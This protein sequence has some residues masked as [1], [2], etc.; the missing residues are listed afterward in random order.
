[1]TAHITIDQS[2][3]TDFCR[4]WDIV[5]FSLFGSVLRDDFRLDSDVDVLVSF[6]QNA[7]HGLFDLVRM[8]DE[9]SEILGRNVDL[10]EREAVEN[11]ENY[12]R[13]KHILSNTECLYVA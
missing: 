12:I 4:R 9:L 10:V 5:E 8:Q 1:M 3:I 13:R 11:S 7:R 6:D 2:K